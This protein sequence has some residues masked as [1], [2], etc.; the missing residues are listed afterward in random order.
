MKRTLKINNFK[1]P[2]EIIF[3][4]FCKIDSLK[5][6]KLKR[7][8]FIIFLNIFLLKIETI[9]RHFMI[10]LIVTRGITKKIHKYLF[11]IYIEVTRA[12]FYNFS[13]FIS[14]KHKLR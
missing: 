1:L 12:L 8:K 4:K 7:E 14:Y 5:I 9:Q 11:L 3:N 10:I 6:F 13:N 2:P